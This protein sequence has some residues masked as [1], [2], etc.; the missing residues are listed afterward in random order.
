MNIRKPVR[1]VSKHHEKFTNNA[2]L[3][4]NGGREDYED[5]ADYIDIRTVLKGRVIA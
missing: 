3:L 2:F 1:R 5:P 4:Y